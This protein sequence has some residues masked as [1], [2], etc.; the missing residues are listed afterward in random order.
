MCITRHYRDKSFAFEEWEPES[1]R[2]GKDYWLR[3]WPIPR[4]ALAAFI[5]MGVSEAKIARYFK[6]GN[7][8]VS[9]LRQKYRL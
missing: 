5:D 3:S 1:E 9:I 2:L 8:D 7:Q 6:T 4:S